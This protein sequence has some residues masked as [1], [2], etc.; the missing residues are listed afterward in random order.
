MLKLFA[1][2]QVIAW[3]TERRKDIPPISH[4]DCP[5]QMATDGPEYGAAA[6]DREEFLPAIQ[7]TPFETLVAANNLGVESLLDL[8]WEAVADLSRGGLEITPAK[9]SVSRTT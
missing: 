4:E 8:Y 6:W 7:K 2:K 5:P 9:C 1:L 3:T